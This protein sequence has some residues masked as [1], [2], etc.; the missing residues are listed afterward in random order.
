MTTKEAFREIKHGMAIAFFASAY[1]DQAE[2]SG[3]PLR[4]EITDQLPDD[5]DPA[6]DHAVNT[7]ISDMVNAHNYG[8]PGLNDAQKLCC[9]YLKVRNVSGGD[10]SDRECT[11]ELFGHYCAMQAM[12][13][14]VGLES[15][16][17]EAYD[18]ITVPY[19]EFGGHSLQKD[20]FG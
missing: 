20:Y 5:I 9:L 16:G 8:E 3:E 1:A 4:G 11:P 10:G 14:G 19:V 13:T 6:V 17:G 18:A 15:F 2:E 12:G 7:L